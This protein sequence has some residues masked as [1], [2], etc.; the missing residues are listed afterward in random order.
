MP[1]RGSSLTATAQRLVSHWA[2]H[3]SRRR[4]LSTAAFLQQVVSEPSSAHRRRQQ[5]TIEFPQIWPENHLITLIC[6]QNMSV[7]KIETDKFDGKSGFVMWWRKMKAVLYGRDGLSLSDVK[8]ALKSNDLDLQK[9][10]KSQGENL[11][12]RGRV[13][14]REPPSHYFKSKERSKSREKNKVKFF[15]CGKEVHM[16]NKCF[17]WIKDEKQRKHGKGSNKTYDL[18]QMV[19]LVFRGFVCVSFSF[20]F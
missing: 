15:Y 9:I 11:F 18:I 7:P 16:K 10:N 13:D 17:K 6:L 14:R 8:N 3:C 1:Q 12:V 2:R 4:P 5:S 19:V 20:M